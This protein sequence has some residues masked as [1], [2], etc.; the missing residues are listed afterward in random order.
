MHCIT[1]ASDLPR[2]VESLISCGGNYTPLPLPLFHFINTLHAHIFAEQKFLHCHGLAT[3]TLQ[4]LRPLL[5]KPNLP[6]NPAQPITSLLR[7]YITTATW[8]SIYFEISPKNNAAIIL[9]PPNAMLTKYT[10]L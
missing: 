1:S 2:L 10:Y 6:T 8:S 3:S 9:T 7:S 5:Q 4:S